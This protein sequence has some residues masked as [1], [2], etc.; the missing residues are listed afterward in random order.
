LADA[1]AGREAARDQWDR[2]AATFDD[3]P[4]HGLREPRVRAAWTARLRGWLPAAPATILDLGCGTGSLSVVMAEL[5]YTVSGLD[6][7]PAMI[8]RARAKASA[9]GR[10]I[11][12]QVMDAAAPSLAPALFDG[13]VCR[14][15]LWA[16][17]RPAEVL[18][19][20]AA[21]LRPGGRL[22]LVE[23]RWGTGA[24]LTPGEVLS[25]LPP[26][27]VPHPV[28]NLSSEPALWGRTVSDERYA[29]VAALA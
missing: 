28:E 17:P 3:E 5:G 19:R 4:D 7:S 15:L 9:A 6:L 1:A 12:F 13:L 10:K 8:A 21:L 26:V 11:A 22:V 2:A 20:W 16:L 18:A 27:L 25:A 29:I 24:G 14:H 23:G